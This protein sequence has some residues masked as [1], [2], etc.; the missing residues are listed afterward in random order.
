MYERYEK[1]LEQ[2]KD[3]PNVNVC[4]AEENLEELHTIESVFDYRFNSSKNTHV[5]LFVTQSFWFL[6]YQY[7]FFWFLLYKYK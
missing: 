3:R 1:R 7:V 6:L 4:A 5:F 2:Q